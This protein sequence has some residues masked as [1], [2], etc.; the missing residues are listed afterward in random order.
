[1]KHLPLNAYISPWILGLIFLA[2]GCVKQDHAQP[3][4]AAH[5][6]ELSG[7]VFIVTQGAQSIKLGLVTVVA[8]PEEEMT[9][10]LEHKRATAAKLKSERQIE[11]NAAEN[12]MTDSRKAIAVSEA[13]IPTAR[14]AASAAHLRYMEVVDWENPEIGKKEKQEQH[15]FERQAVAKQQKVQARRKTL[16]AQQITLGMMKADRDYLDT[17]DYYFADLPAGIAS[18][19]T[20]ADGLF[21]MTIPQQ[22]KFALAAHASRRILDREENYYWLVWESLDGKSTKTVMLSND[23]ITTSGSPDSAITLPR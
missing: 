1:M 10:F 21:T 9:T 11:I 6:G 16:A 14:K 19:K 2:S 8:I 4:N 7:E 17:S 15:M 23:N 13:A 5:D 12:A 18:A 3:A 20:N 22:G